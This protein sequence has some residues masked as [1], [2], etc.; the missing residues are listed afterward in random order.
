MQ[1]DKRYYEFGGISKS[2]IEKPSH[3]FAQTVGKLFGGSAHPTGKRQNG[4]TRGCENEQMTLWSEV[5]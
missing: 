1:S 2:R 5:L 4:K 3:A